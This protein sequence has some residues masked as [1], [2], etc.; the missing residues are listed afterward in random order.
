[1]KLNTMEKLYL[2]MKNE[3]PE[4]ILSDE[5]IINAKKPIIRML[6]IS[7]NLGLI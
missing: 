4:I 1:M 5:L 6:D 7:R 3:Q 2:A